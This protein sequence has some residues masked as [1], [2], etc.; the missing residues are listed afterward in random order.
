MKYDLVNKQWCVDVP[1]GVSTDHHY[2]F[3]VGFNTSDP[4]RVVVTWHET[5]IG[6]GSFSMQGT[7]T[8][9]AAIID[10]Y[11]RLM[12]LAVAHAALI[13]QTPKCT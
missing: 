5:T 10:A 2:E 6:S 9:S 12:L 7:T 3:D 8:L 1:T 11:K 4:Q 13:T